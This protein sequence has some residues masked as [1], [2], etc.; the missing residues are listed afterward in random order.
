[1]FNKKST[2]RSLIPAA[3][4]ACMLILA[5]CATGPYGSQQRG[6]QRGGSY[7]TTYGNNG[8]NY[9]RDNCP[10]NQCGV[11]RSVDQVYVNGGNNSHLLGT[12]IGAVVGGALGNQVGKGDGRN[13]ATVVGAVAGGVAG[14]QVAKHTGNNNGNSTTAWR[15]VVRLDNG[16]TATVT[17]RENPRA[18]NGDR[19]EVRDGHVYLL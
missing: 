8:G 13:A 16:R 5:G 4:A 2:L 17:Q 12:I 1:M 15:V 14:N 18:R 6:Q 9:N 3:L 19:V 10:A 11:V 7:G